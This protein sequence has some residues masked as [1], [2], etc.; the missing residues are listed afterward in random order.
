VTRHNWIENDSEQIVTY[1]IELKTKKSSDELV[2]DDL[3]IGNKKY[4]FQISHH[5]RKII[6]RFN[7]KEI[8]ILNVISEI[9]NDSQE[10]IPKSILKGIVILGYSFRKKKKFVSVRQFR[11]RLGLKLVPL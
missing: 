6:S 11:E 4:K 9:K 8:V 5:E 10:E 2:F 7:K 1:Q 3:W